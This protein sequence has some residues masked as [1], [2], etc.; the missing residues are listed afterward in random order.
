MPQNW[1]RQIPLLTMTPIDVSQMA[2]LSYELLP[3]YRDDAVSFHA[4]LAFAAMHRATQTIQ[5]SPLRAAEV[6]GR[7]LQMLKERVEE[8]PTV[9]SNGTILAVGVMVN[10]EV[11]IYHFFISAATLITSKRPAGTMKPQ[12]STG[13]HSRK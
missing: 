3:L 7:A 4:L 6:E 13:M 2:Y 1:L 9:Q 12:G 5:T 10:L 11:R 8:R